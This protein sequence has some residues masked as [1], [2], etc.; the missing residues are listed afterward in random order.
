MSTDFLRLCI[1]GPGLLG[2]SLALAVQRY[3]PH[4]RLAVWAR[5]QRDFA[6]MR[7]ALGDEVELSCDLN[8]CVASADLLIF[9]TPIGYM[10][11]LLQSCLGSI[12]KHCLIS[13]VGSTKYELHQQLEAICA[14]Q[15]LHYIGSHPMAGS[16]QQGFAAARADLFLD[17]SVVLTTNPCSDRR[18][19]QRQQQLRAALA[20]FW[21]SLGA[22]VL[23]LSPLQ[24]DRAVAS[25]SHFPH[26]MA[27]L[28]SLIATDSSGHPGVLAGGGYRDTTRVAG[29]DA[30]MWSEIVLSNAQAILPILKQAG[31]Q[32]EL[33]QQLV[34]SANAEGLQQW[35]EQARQQ[36]MQA[37]LHGS[38]ALGAQNDSSR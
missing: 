36:R 20:N 21:S 5:T 8:K 37:L 7:A 35:L 33:L 31:A 26:L 30:T 13:D 34:E 23:E 1:V 19:Q 14:P 16:E 32:L 4:M 25:I 28:T 6:A 18:Q 38:E 12:D 3:L 15:G 9:A 10:P 2:G 11:E 24:H 27:S 17:A 22:N 29:G